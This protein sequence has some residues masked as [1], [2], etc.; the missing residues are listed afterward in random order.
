MNPPPTPV[1]ISDV[2]AAA[3]LTERKRIAQELHDTLLQGSRR[4]DAAPRY[5]G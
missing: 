3:R 2:V 1:A 4:I 5:R